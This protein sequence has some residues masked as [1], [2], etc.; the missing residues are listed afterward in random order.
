MSKRFPKILSFLISFVFIFNIFSQIAFASNIITIIP[1]NKFSYLDSLPVSSVDGLIV[2]LKPDANYRTVFSNTDDNI[3]STIDELNISKIKRDKNKKLSLQALELSNDSNV[4][5][6]EPDYVKNIS[7]VP[8]DTYYDNQWG[9]PSINAPTAWDVTAGGSNSTIIAIID[10]GVDITHPDLSP[11]IIPG[12]NA[13]NDSTIVTDEHG[14]GTHVAGIAAARINNTVGIAGLAGN[15]KIMPIKVAGASGSMLTSNVAKGIIWA[16]DNG[17]KVINL[18]LGGTGYTQTENDA[19][20]Y[21]YNKGV[22]IVAA[23]GNS[24]TSAAHYPADF[25]HVISVGSVGKTNVKSSFSNYGPTLDVVAPGESIYSSIKGGGYGNMQGT[26]M[27]SPYVAGLAALIVSEKPDLAPDQV[28]QIITSTC[29]D[30]GTVGFDNT[31]GN[32]LINAAQALNAEPDTTSPVLTLSNVVPAAFKPS[33]ASKITLNFTLSENAYVTCGVY[34]S[35]NVLIKTLLSKKVFS[36][37]DSFIIWDGKTSSN[38]LVTNGTYTIRLSALDAAGN[39][40]NEITGSIS[41]DTIAP[42]ISNVTVSNNPF[43]PNNNTMQTITYTISENAIVN[44]TLYSGTSPILKLESGVEK[45]SGTYSATWDGKNVSGV[46]VNNGPYKFSVDAADSCGNKSAPSDVNFITNYYTTQIKTLSETPHYLYANGTN[47]TAIKFTLSATSNVKLDILN[48]DGDIIKNIKTGSVPALGATVYWD[49]K[50]ANGSIVTDGTYTYKLAVLDSSNTELSAISGA[51]VIDTKPAEISSIFATPI[52]LTT[53]DIVTLKYTL[54]E[55]SKVTV[56]IHDYFNKKVA[57]V[58]SGVVQNIGD[59]SVTWNSK[60]LSVN[61]YDGAYTFKLYVVDMSG[62]PTEVKSIPFSIN[63]VATEIKS[64]TV[65]SEIFNPSGAIKSATLTYTLSE[66]CTI[67]AVVKNSS[68][69]VIRTLA[70]NLYT[71]KITGTNIWDGKDNASAIV[72]NGTYII[73][74]TAKG[75]DDSTATISKTVTVDSTAPT[76]T[77]TSVSPQM[78]NSVQAVTLIYTLSEQSLVTVDILDQFNTKVLTLLSNAKQNEGENTVTWNNIAIG[79]KPAIDGIYT[80]K[81]T[82]IDNVKLSSAPVVGTFTINTAPTT[83]TIS[84]TPEAFKPTGTSMATIK[85]LISEPCKATLYIKNSSNQA[86]RTLITDV[87]TKANVALST[88]WNGKNF[89]GTIAESG[90]YNAVLALTDTAG[91]TVE[92]S[93]T[94]FVIDTVAPTVTD[95]SATPDKLNTRQ[96]VSFRY[97]LSETSNVTVDVF[98]QFNTKIIT[99]LNN[100]KQNAAENTAT[101]NNIAIGTKQ[102]TDGI[103]TYK[104]TAVDNVK[105]ASAPASGTFIINTA[106]TTATISATPEYFKPSGSSTISIKHIVSEPCKATLEVKDTDGNVVRTLYKDILQK[107]NTSITSVWNARNASGVIVEDGAY[108]GVLTLIDCEG[109]KTE[110]STTPIY[111]DTTTPTLNDAT[112]SPSNITSKQ[113]VTFRYTLSETSN[114]TIDIYDQFNAKV[115]TI[116]NAVKQNSG[117]NTAIWNNIAVGTKQAVDGIYTYRI[118]AVDNVKMPSAPATGTFTINAASTTA[119]ISVTPNVFRPTGS[120]TAAIKY[121]LSEP[122]NVIASIKD[123]HGN[124]VKTLLS[125][126]LQ[127]ANT[128]LSLSWN[129]KND[130][131]SI[132]ENGTYTAEFSLTDCNG[133]E[134]IKTASINVDFTPPTISNITVSEDPFDYSKL[135]EYVTIGFTSNEDCTVTV[136][137]TNGTS[138]VRALV[139][140]KVISAGAYS[141]VWYANDTRNYVVPAGTYTINITARDAVGNSSTIKQN[142]IFTRS[143]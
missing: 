101:W 78:V 3:S 92:K 127:K 105:Q 52:N 102:A 96:S 106:A 125:N 129:G 98:D 108:T 8:D 31:Y 56:D 54:S 24:N 75:S 42:V 65:N 22:T 104:I 66:P 118:T 99:L 30:L 17:A 26:S 16:A 57:S 38:A 15:C 23:K 123:S 83:A 126:V 34:N 109:N 110:K 67:T 111:I 69:D 13:L 107:S 131:G 5:Y 40:S 20:Q 50:D 77:N 28:S 62:V 76:V 14:H 72:A 18:S 6:V 7:Y 82:A 121:T 114:V 2:K 120:N 140:G 116:L 79:G 103:Y 27:A 36:K 61:A 60:I 74:F 87:L 137:I 59:N 97:T 32:G 93:S 134:V 43:S 58:L 12:Y 135:G 70:S 1:R 51:I 39:L 71:G 45:A 49:G 37:G 119:T 88:T 25:E 85:Y 80:Y 11:N 44:V 64:A 130:S 94:A 115:T 117:E 46:V 53:N 89:D 138:L 84:V 10:T 91:N 29:T 133:D 136:S 95:V 128:S 4:L 142:L 100:I 68:G 9:L 47:R 141:T 112:V 122:C 139:S 132:V 86:V 48:S 35:S 143:F 81:I 21:A 73:E 33:T 55:K 41:A 90:T 19:V 124:T 113:N 63:R